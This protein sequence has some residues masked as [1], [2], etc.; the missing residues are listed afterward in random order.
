MCIKVLVLDTTFYYYFYDYPHSVLTF[1]ISY[2]T[3]TLLAT[4]LYHISFIP[5]NKS[6][7]IY[8]YTQVT[9]EVQTGKYLAC[10]YTANKWQSQKTGV[11][12]GEREGEHRAEEIISGRTSSKIKDVRQQCSKMKDVRQQCLATF[13]K[14]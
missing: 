2:S 1:I 13:A 8:F 4:S 7:E 3:Y 9:E 5:H 12:W 11:M 10:G 14:S 6:I